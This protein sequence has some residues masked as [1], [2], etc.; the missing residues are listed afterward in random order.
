[1]NDNYDAGETFVQ[2]RDVDIDPSRHNGPYIGHKAVVDS[3]AAVAKFLQE[4]EAGTAKPLN[5]SIPQ[6]HY[7]TYPGITDVIRQRLRR[8]RLALGELPL[9]NAVS[10]HAERVRRK[11]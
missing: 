3:L 5:H 4:L 9:K 7:Y 11:G 6:S 8:R 10:I 2:G 1:M